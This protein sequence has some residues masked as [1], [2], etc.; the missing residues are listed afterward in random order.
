MDQTA[1]HEPVKGHHMQS[2]KPR[3]LSLEYI[4]G[5]GLCG[6]DQGGVTVAEITA[7]A[8]QLCPVY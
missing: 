7:V 3:S 2:P 6:V 4:I 5:S 1:P 8:L